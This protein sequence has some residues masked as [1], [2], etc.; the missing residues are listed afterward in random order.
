MRAGTLSPWPTGG[1]AWSPRASHPSLARPRHTPIGHDLGDTITSAWLLT[2]RVQAVT[3]VDTHSC[4]CLSH[5]H[6]ID[7]SVFPVGSKQHFPV[8]FSFGHHP[9]PLKVLHKKPSRCLPLGP[10]APEPMPT[11]RRE[12]SIRCHPVGVSTRPVPMAGVVQPVSFPQSSQL[13]EGVGLAGASVLA[14]RGGSGQGQS[15]GPLPQP[16]APG[17]PLT[18]HF[19]SLQR[20]VWSSLYLHRESHRPQVGSQGHQETDTQ[21]QGSKGWLRG[22]ERGSSEWVPLTSLHPHVCT[23]GLVFEPCCAEDGTQIDRGTDRRP[24]HR[25]PKPLPMNKTPQLVNFSRG[26]PLLG[27]G[28]PCLLFGSVRQTLMST[29]S[30]PA[31]GVGG[32][33]K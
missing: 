14:H 4:H 25:D 8:C 3:W 6:T 10:R 32:P 18:P 20:Q 29:G 28:R 16:R 17:N 12:L 5:R 30:G 13:Q 27:M 33:P 22:K 31:W 19:F 9:D 11:T 15:T 2:P 26:R 21:R 1:R 23:R 7:H 24:C